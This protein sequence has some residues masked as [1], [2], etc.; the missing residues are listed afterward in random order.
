MT[1]PSIQIGAVFLGRSMQKTQEMREDEVG[2]YLE[3]KLGGSNE[4]YRFMQLQVALC[5]YMF[6]R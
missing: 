3:L 5:T 2:K 4:S 6:V 1:Y